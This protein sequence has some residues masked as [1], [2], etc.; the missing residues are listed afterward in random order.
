M[1]KNIKKTAKKRLQKTKKAKTR[2]F[3]IQVTE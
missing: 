3:G 2:T 1:E